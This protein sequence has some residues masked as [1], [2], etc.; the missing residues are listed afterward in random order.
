M[1]MMLCFEFC[2]F[3]P[4]VDLIIEN[5][6][7]IFKNIDVILRNIECS[8]NIQKPKYKFRK[9]FWLLSQMRYNG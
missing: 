7:V 1:N 4:N 9:S 6:N 3:C 5:N 2:L 8:K